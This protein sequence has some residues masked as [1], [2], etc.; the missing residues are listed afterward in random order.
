MI[1]LLSYVLKFLLFCFSEWQPLKEYSVGGVAK[2]INQKKKKFFFRMELREDGILY[3]SGSPDKVEQAKAQIDDFLKETRQKF[4]DD[5]SPKKVVMKFNHSKSHTSFLNEIKEDEQYYELLN[6]IN[7]EIKDR[8]VYVKGDEAKQIKFTVFLR[9]KIITKAMFHESNDQKKSFILGLS[10]NQ[11]IQL[12]KSQRLPKCSST[13]SFPLIQPFTSMYQSIP[14]LKPELVKALYAL[15][16][17]MASSYGELSLKFHFGQAFFNLK[18]GKYKVAEIE[19]NQYAIKYQRIDEATITSILPIQNWIVRKKGCRYDFRIYTPEPYIDIRYKVFLVEDD[20]GSTVFKGIQ[21]AKQVMEILKEGP[22]FL[23]WPE[24]GV[25]RFDIVS[26]K[27]D[28]D[29]RLR[30]K[31]FKSNSDYEEKIKYH[32]EYLQN[33]FFSKLKTVPR[34]F[35]LEYPEL[36]D[37]YVLSYCRQSVR[38]TYSVPSTSLEVKLSNETILV[39]YDRYDS[40]VDVFDVFVEDVNVKKALDGNQWSPDDIADRYESVFNFGKQILDLL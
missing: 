25:K 11:V 27:K 32:L 19:R 16:D 3:V 8:E 1:Y 28:L 31:M 17:E 13:A 12:D 36:S 26:P 15:K 34:S 14:D 39:N 9:H 10:L 37:G 4:F 20:N 18:P 40:S 2:F 21:D 6:G 33:N 23:T 30:I 5:S 22:G 35:K 29:L 38:E 24:A 7:I